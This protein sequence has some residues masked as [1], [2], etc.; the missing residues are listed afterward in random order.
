MPSAKLDRPLESAIGAAAKWANRIGLIAVVLLMLLTVADVVLRY[1]FTKPVLGTVE[2]TEYAMVIIVS[3]AFARCADTE[4]HA[5]IDMLVTHFSP[6]M[7]TIVN[8]MVYIITLGFCV[9]MTW[10]AFVDFYKLH[11]A[12]RRSAILEI[13]AS[14][15][16][17][18]L[19]IGFV[20]LCLVL[21]KK[22]AETFR[23]EPQR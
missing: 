5:R 19:S 18:V 3:L 9:L 6:K 11:L 7:K 13:P 4:S 2:L 21:V 17:L 23:K 8:A 22:I 12:G 16:H 10:R 20:L 1:V 14:P 15:F